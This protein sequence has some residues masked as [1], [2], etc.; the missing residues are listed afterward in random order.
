MGR[1]QTW[2][3]HW[4][5]FPSVCSIFCPCISFRQEQFWIKNFE[6][7]LVTTSLHW[8]PCLSTGGGLFSFHLPTVGQFWL[9]SPP[10]SSGSLPQAKFLGLSRSSPKPS[11]L[12][13][14][15]SWPSRLLSYLPP[16]L[17]LPPS[18]LLSYPGPSLPLPPMITLFPFLSGIEASQSRSR[19]KTT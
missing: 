19:R 6:G 7:Q 3:G 18:L 4:M 12:L 14:H 8:G 13:L 15:I 2:S 5:A 9:R 10:L 16:Y 11:P 1:I 17:V